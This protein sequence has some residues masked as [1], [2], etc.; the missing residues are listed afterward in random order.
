MAE[1]KTTDA[2]IDLL[3]RIIAR[4]H[5]NELE[6]AWLAAL[7]E[8]PAETSELLG[9]LHALTRHGDS[10]QVG[11]LLLFLLQHTVEKKGNSAAL[12]IVQRAAGL[13][14]SKPSDAFIPTSDDLRKTIAD[15]YRG[16]KPVENTDDMLKMTL[17]DEELPIDRALICLERLYA[18]QPG[19]YVLDYKTTGRVIKVDSAK[20]TLEVEMP[21]EKRTYS[22]EKLDKLKKLEKDDF[23]G[24]QA[25]EPETLKALAKDDPAALVILALKA[26]GPF[27][28]FKEMKAYLTPVLPGNNWTKWWNS[29]KTALKLHPL[30][31]VS[32]DTQP[33]FGLRMKPVSY[34][35]EVRAKFHS[36]ATPEE[37]MLAAFDYVT[38]T[39]NDTETMKFI[40]EKIAAL[41]AALS[42]ADPLG[43]AACDGIIA[44]IKKKN[45]EAA[46]VSVTA[47]QLPAEI[48]PGSLHAIDNQKLAEFALNYVKANEPRWFEIFAAVMPNAEA[49]TCDF[50]ANELAKASHI[51]LLRDTYT[52]ILARPEQSINALIWLW[53]TS[54]T[55]K[56]P[57]DSPGIDG[58]A[59][60]SRMFSVVDSLSRK[61]SS[62]EPQYKAALNAVVRAL[63]LREGAIFQAALEG[64]AP[65]QLKL[66]R[67]TLERTL[68]LT[69]HTRA[70]LTDRIRHVHPAM[71]AK[72]VE[73]WEDEFIYTTEAGLKR[74]Q[75]E[76][77]H[78]VNVKLSEASK[79]VGTAA[80]DGDLSENFAW[81]AA[82]AER[83][84]LAGTASRMQAEISKARVITH[85]II[86]TDKVNVGC[87]V[88]AK[89][90]AT[91]EVHT[92]YFFGPWDADHD[93]GIYSYKA[94]LGLAFM[95]KK[96]GELAIHKM[97]NV[98]SV[99]EILSIKPGM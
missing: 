74:R 89:N 75:E 9:V 93:K 86:Q 50:I 15:I 68:A 1:E 76:L 60:V 98:Q 94:S 17:L 45:P 51:D 59:L 56:L 39:S 38:G 7:A 10:N 26:L 25:F 2:R 85:E 81:T 61:T 35:E 80:A 3:R 64:A 19:E 49:E 79:A 66:V 40:A 16:A 77:Y 46:A 63:T 33:S 24:R 91:G 83:D 11:S 23:R 13:P 55:G 90:D 41:G 29:A 14:P 6:P 58:V 69:D 72:H 37:K 88:E 5:Y 73:M 53:R 54:L 27:L 47:C 97:E 52:A 99:W 42:H 20:K 43:C 78:L 44:E 84:R 96:V 87:V 21:A 65:D 67:A 30:I 95:G 48:L 31:M 57:K 82:L 34:E 71:F 70:Q 36:K 22:C 32:D 62:R 18:F 4:R 28:L 92:F 12:E 8:P